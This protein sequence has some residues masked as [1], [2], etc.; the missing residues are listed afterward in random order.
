[1][2][3]GTELWKI[4]DAA[5]ANGRADAPPICCASVQPCAARGEVMAQHF[6]NELPQ[7]L[8]WNPGVVYD[9]IP[10]WWVR[11]LDDRLQVELVA[12]RLETFQTILQAQV[13]GLGKAAQVLRGK[14]Q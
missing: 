9:P 2:G 1:L 5:R 14:G 6:E 8:R 13:E 12:I 3:R 4:A 7:L 11:E 10:E